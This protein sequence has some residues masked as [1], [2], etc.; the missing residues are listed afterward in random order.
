MPAAITADQLL[1]RVKARAQIPS[2]E[3]RLTDAEILAL[4]DDAILL[5][6]G[7]EMYD[8]DDGR[9]I[10]T[11]ADADVTSGTA[12]YRIP[13]RAWSS[14]VDSV[15]L[16][17]SQGNEIPLAYVDRTEIAMWQQGGLWAAPCF[18]ILGDRIKLLPTPTDSAYDLRVRYV[19]R[20]SRLVLI[21]DAAQVKSV[22]PTTWDANTTVPSAWGATEILDYITGQTG[23]SLADSVST[24]YS[25]PNFTPATMPSELQALDYACLA[26]ESCVVQA[27]DTAIPYLA[28]LVA[29]DVCVALGDN[30]GADRCAALA[31]QRRRDVSQALAERSRTRPKVIN[32]NSP[33]RGGGQRGRRLWGLR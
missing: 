7:R 28:D 13:A 5:S 32:R 26:G 15:A 29:R 18:T 14:G 24:G 30:E 6:L 3:G 4:A 17:D 22:G 27:P 1:A 20:P 9:W 10:Q 16:I 12:D 25:T 11:A 23:D 33:L 8:A 19:R 2:T 31:E 21:E